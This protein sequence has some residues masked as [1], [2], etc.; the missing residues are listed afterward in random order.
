MTATTSARTKHR[1]PRPIRSQHDYAAAVAEIDRLLETDPAPLSD[2]ADRLELLALVVEAFDD[3]HHS[4]PPRA[5]PPAVVLFALDQQG[6][7]RADLV[8]I[9][10]SKS[11]VSEFLTGK[12]RL[13]LPQISALRRELRIPADLLIEAESAADRRVDVREPRVSR[14]SEPAQAY[15]SGPPNIDRLLPVLERVVERLD[16]V[17]ALLAKK[18]RAESITA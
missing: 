12:R 5:S 6:R 14:V 11:R 9:L 8:P 1:S 18:V 3:K 13:S 7:A 16:T 4:L 10:G 15:G 17:T 2:A